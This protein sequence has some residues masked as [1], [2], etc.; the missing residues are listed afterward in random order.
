M[1]LNKRIMQTQKK[2]REKKPKGE[3]YRISAVLNRKKSCR[4]SCF[5]YK[6]TDVSILMF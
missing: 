1:Y 3:K 4:R 2:T 6:Q 5:I